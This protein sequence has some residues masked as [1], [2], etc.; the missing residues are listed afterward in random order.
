MPKSLLFNNNEPWIKKGDPQMFDFTMGS[1]DGAEVCE[2]VCLFILH[3]LS[4]AY[5]N[6]SI[7]LYRDDGQVAFKNVSART[8]DK[9]RK[10]V[11]LKINA[12]GNLKIVNYLDITLNHT[13]GKFYPFGKLKNN[14]LYINI[15]SNYPH[16]PPTSQ[17]KH[18]NINIVLWPRVTRSSYVSL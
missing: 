9:T 17:H 4:S 7:S 13:T 15:R 6:G 2:R 14:S 18:E 11:G 5:P 16:K 10:N 3:L 12:L 1:H 8:L